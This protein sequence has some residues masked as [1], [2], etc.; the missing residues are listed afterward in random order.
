[1]APVV[2]ARPL[3]VQ[4]SRRY[5]YISGAFSSKRY[6][7]VFGPIGPVA[8]LVHGHT[9]THNLRLPD[10]GKRRVRRWPSGTSLARPRFSLSARSGWGGRPMTSPPDGCVWPLFRVQAAAMRLPP[11]RIVTLCI[12][13]YMHRRTREVGQLSRNRCPLRVCNRLSRCRPIT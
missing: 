8:T 10:T 11:R 1:M 3:E 13:V 6:Q 5:W 4:G 9:H 12:H 7:S 2:S